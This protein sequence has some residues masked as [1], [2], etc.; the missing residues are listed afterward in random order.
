MA[1]VLGTVFFLLAGA[2][3]AEPAGF[4]RFEDGKVGQPAGVVASQTGA[5]A[6]TGKAG[7]CGKGAPPVYDGE[8]PHKELWD[9]LTASLVAPAS[10]A[11]LRF[12]A[13]QDATGGAPVGGEV[14]V[15]GSNAAASP[16]NFTLE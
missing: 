6:M 1:S 8:V 16:Q 2:V 5:A 3:C 4:W 11:S 13:P 10:G 7:V 12:H 14:V 15:S 9:G